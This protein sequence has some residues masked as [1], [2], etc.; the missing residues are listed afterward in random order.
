MAKIPGKK[1]QRRIKKYDYD[2]KKLNLKFVFVKQIRQ[3]RPV[4]DFQ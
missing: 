4:F 1:E 3:Y 2:H